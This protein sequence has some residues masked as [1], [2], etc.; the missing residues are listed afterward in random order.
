MQAFTLLTFL[1]FYCS[2]GMF[3]VYFPVA[4]GICLSRVYLCCHYFSD[5]IA[6]AFM[7]ILVCT[8]A[9]K[10]VLGYLGVE[11]LIDTLLK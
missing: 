10:G 3:W 4:V 11:Q 1:Y 6:G 7:G 8:V 9:V 2:W 5:I